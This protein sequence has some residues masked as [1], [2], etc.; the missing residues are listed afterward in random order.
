MGWKRATFVIL[1]AFAVLGGSSAAAVGR[2]VGSGAAP[3]TTPVL[4]TDQVA[5]PAGAV[6]RPLPAAD[7]VVLTLTLNNPRSSELDR[8]LAAIEDPASPAYRHF[9]TFAE[10]VAAFAPSATSVQFVEAELA[11]NGATDISAA[12]D[13]SSVTAV[14]PAASVDRLLGVDLVTYGVSTASGLYTALGV[15]SLPSGLSGLVRGITGLS[16]LASRALATSA[17]T[18]TVASPPEASTPGQFVYDPTSGEDWFLGS[19]YTQAYGATDL[20]PGTHSVS[21]ATYPT[22]AAIATLLGSA[23][24]QSTQTNLPPWDPAVVDSY[25]NGSLGPGWP[26]PQLTGVPVTVAG[27]TPPLPGSFGSLNDSTLF[28]YENSLDLEMA[29]S[30]APGASLYNFYFAG[31]LLIGPTTLGDAASYLTDDLAAALAYDYA[32]QHLTTVSCSFGLPDLDY[33]GWDAELATAAAMGVTI[34]SASGDQGNA[35]NSLS[36]R[37]DGQWPIWP[38]TAAT[39]TSGSISVGGVSVSLTG[40]PTSTFNGTSLNL[41]YDPDA[42][43]LS[44]VSAWWDTSGGAGTFAGSEG[45]ASTL[46]AEPYWQ[47]HSAAQPAVVNA[48]VLQGAGALGRSGPDLAMPGNATI[49]TVFANS[50]G[51]VFFVVLEGTS[52]AAPLLAGLLADVVAVEN[53]RSGGTWSSLGF[54]DPEIYQFAS[55]FETHPAASGNPFLDVVTGHNYVFSAAP[56]WDAVTGWGGV[57]ASAFLAADGNST[58]RA[59][60]YDGPTPGLPSTGGSGTPSIPWTYVY[61]IFGVGIVVALVVVFAAYR[62]ARRPPAAAAG[63]PW[64]ARAGGPMPPPPPPPGTYPG[65][66]FLCP[67]CGAVRPSEPVRCPQCGAF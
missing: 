10:Y 67:Y 25:F 51:T 32:P 58:L 39:N 54:I 40:S 65:A 11:Q 12:P 60:V 8:F 43:M 41:T 15:P 34:A 24:N 38:A 37:D 46:Y 17:T 7:S 63:V 66:T 2:A 19:D 26:T 53:N 31:S 30:M 16:D 47:F 59:Y 44:T 6:A 49:A 45:G 4:T 55:Y 35:P 61:A 27:V 13:R 21:N 22:T 20:F 5:L 57:L 23:Y 42:G 29:G 9:L 28:E 33:T 64:G 50:T 36:G 3:N 14:L 18:L 52:V 48:T 1:V 62:G 56:G